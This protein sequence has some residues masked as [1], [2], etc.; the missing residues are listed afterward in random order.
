MKQRLISE[1]ALVKILDRLMQS[2]SKNLIRDCIHRL[3]LESAIGSVQPASCVIHAQGWLDERLSFDPSNE[4]CFHRGD[5]CAKMSLAKFMQ[6]AEISHNDEGCNRMI[7]VFHPNR[8]LGPVE[9]H[10]VVKMSAND[11][12]R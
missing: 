9:V 4:V 8:G 7:S 1:P 5:H 12:M 11:R 2:S 6:K 10:A 3:D